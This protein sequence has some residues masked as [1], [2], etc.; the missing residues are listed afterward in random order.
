M[1][2]AQQLA[3][4]MKDHQELMRKNQELMQ[5]QQATA[6]GQ[7]AQIKSLQETV[8]QLGAVIA[9]KSD[10]APGTFVPPDKMAA[11]ANLMDTF[12][13]EPESDL[14]F[15]AWFDRY[16]DVLAVDGKS[17]GDSGQ[18]RLLL[19]KLDT[20]LNEQYRHS[21]LPELPSTKDF[22]TTV[23]SLK[24]MFVK[25]YSLFRTRW[26]CLQVSRRSDELLA[27]YGARVNK[28]AESFLLK[29]LTPDQFKCLLFIQG[30]HDPRDK[31]IRTR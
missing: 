28:L 31:N 19:M 8:T 14:T 25:K 24:T 30:I 17:L 29:E 21:I 5:S 13:Y 27:A 3:D 16:A 9:G 2:L 11:L 20:P 4:M 7:A 1:E 26:D 15:K 6:K 18:V 10:A 12:V 23:A 22:A